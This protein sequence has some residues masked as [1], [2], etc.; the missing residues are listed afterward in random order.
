MAEASNPNDARHPLVDFLTTTVLILSA[1]PSGKLRSNFVA[2]L[3]IYGIPEQGLQP[4]LL[5]EFNPARLV[6]QGL[7]TIDY[8]HRHGKLHAGATCMVMDS[9]GLILLIRRGPHLV[10]CPN[11]WGVV[12]EHRLGLEPLEDNVKRGILEELG[13]EVWN[14]VA[15][16]Q[17]LTTFPVYMKREVGEYGSKGRIDHQ[18][19]YMWVVTLDER[20]ENVRLHL[21][22]EVSDH[23]W[24]DA[25]VYDKWVKQD[26]KNNNPPKDFCHP[27]VAGLRSYEIDR[28]QELKAKN[29]QS[30]DK[31]PRQSFF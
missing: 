30:S 22:D 21:D 5:Q 14:H 18:L 29:N 1:K 17:N 12:G 8:A 3:Q 10:T 6:D 2:D 28:L 4:T 27:I 11:A 24:I 20:H 31:I 26:L 19:L 13:E 7:V 16:V 9:E 23:R 25:D 15:K